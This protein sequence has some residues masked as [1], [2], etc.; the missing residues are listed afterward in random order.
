[1]SVRAGSEVL[2][3]LDAAQCRLTRRGRKRR[4][5]DR[6]NRLYVRHCRLPHM[7]I[8]GTQRRK[9]KGLTG[10]QGQSQDLTSVKED[11]GVILQNPRRQGGV[12]TA[13]PAGLSVSGLAPTPRDCSRSW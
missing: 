6:D 8:A 2:F 13:A 3:E 1:E 4:T 5:E 12:Y 11:Q 7:A 9:R 10:T